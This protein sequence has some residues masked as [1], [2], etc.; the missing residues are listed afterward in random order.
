MTSET[1][2]QNLLP[3][4]PTLEKLLRD[5]GATAP[6]RRLAMTGDASSRTYSRIIDA[7]LRSWVVM[8]MPPGPHSLA[9]EKTPGDVGRIQELPFVNMQRFLA[10]NKV[11]VPKLVGQAEPYLVLEDLGDRTVYDWIQ[12][13][14][15]DTA[16]LEA[17][18]R[19]ALDQLLLIHHAKPGPD[20]IASTRRFDAKLYNWEFDHFIEY[21]LQW[22]LDSKKTYKVLRNYFQSLSEKLAVFPLCLTHRD[23]HSKNLML[24][25]NGSVWVIDFQDAIMAP[26]H[27]DLASLLFDSYVDLEEKSCNRLID[28]YFENASDALTG[29]ASIEQFHHE[30]RMMALQRNLK[31]AGRFVYIYGVKKKAT[32]VPYII[33]TMRKVQQHLR[34]LGADDDFL[35]HLPF[36]AIETAVHEKLGA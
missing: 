13:A 16:A 34:V 3:T 25:D 7:K 17:V 1:L 21:G 36:A 20:C 33:P 15:P 28:Y 29:G 4:D 26:C 9:E 32:H 8:Q 24:L 30:L 27:Y 14:Q 2:A 6:W 35:K 12:T 22:L 19:K 10:Q 11:Q 31:A 5:A 18:Y 23:Y